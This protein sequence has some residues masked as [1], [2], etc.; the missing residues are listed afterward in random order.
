MVCFD[1][2]ATGTWEDGQNYCRNEMNSDLATILNEDDLNDALQIIGD[3]KVYIG[4]RSEHEAGF[5]EFVDETECPK[6]FTGACVDGSLFKEGH[7]IKCTD[8]G[9][10]CTNLS[11]LDGKINNDVHCLEGLECILCNCENSANGEWNG[12]FPKPLSG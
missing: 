3:K 12:P 6:G 1:N 7:P 5:F 4:L 9:R 10:M 8:G 2:G 11:G